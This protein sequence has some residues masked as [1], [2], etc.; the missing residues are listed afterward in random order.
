MMRG[1]AGLQTIRDRKDGANHT[2]RT[3]GEKRGRERRAE[4]RA[5]VGKEG[6][7]GLLAYITAGCNQSLDDCNIGGVCRVYEYFLKML[8]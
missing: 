1:Q 6:R 5:E 8:S 4:R 2:E 3:R 7:W